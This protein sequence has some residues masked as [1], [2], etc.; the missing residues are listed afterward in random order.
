MVAQPDRDLLARREEA[1][2]RLAVTTEALRGLEEA[3][4]AEPGMPAGTAQALLAGASALC[5]VAANTGTELA[6]SIGPH[7]GWTVDVGGDATGPQLR[8]RRSGD[9]APPAPRTVRGRRRPAGRPA[10]PRPR[11]DPVTRHRTEPEPAQRRRVGIAAKLGLVMGAMTVITVLVAAVLFVQLRQVTTTYDGI[12]G[13][14]VRSAS[15]AREMQVEFKKQVQEWKDILLRGSAPDDLATYTQQFHDESAKVDQLGRDLIATSP[16]DAVRG[17]VTQ[18]LTEHATLNANYE[19][20]LAPFVA[21]GAKDPTVPDRAVRG[22]DRP[23]TAR[24]DGLVGRL[25]TA[26]ADRAAAQSARVAEPAAGPRRRRA[27]R[28][29]VPAGDAGLRGGRRRPPDPGAHRGRRTRP[30]TGRSR[31]PSAGSAARPAT[32]PRSCPRCRSAP[33]TSCT[34]SRTR[35]APCRTARSGWP[36]TS[37]APSARPPRSW[38]TSGAAT[39]A[40]SSARSAT[41]ASWR[42]TRTTPTCS[43]GCSA[44]TT[45]RPASGATPRAC[46]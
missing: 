33:A 35:S 34:T 3:L 15:A 4:A 7:H 14:E 13:S 28:A 20:A 21:A 32:G 38:S 31:T 39:R 24:I 26:V 16:D 41:S 44:W 45:R 27:G 1:L 19:A 8:L 37:T 25:E 36:S 40:C 6:V 17:E 18:F 10:P 23:P 9:P 43:P 30:P 46:W 29:A 22:Q 5:P 42:P 2:A 11:A 12:L